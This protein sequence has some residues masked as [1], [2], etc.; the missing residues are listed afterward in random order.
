MKKALL[1]TFSLITILI[2]IL[3]FFSLYGR[4]L[5]QAEVCNALTLSMKQAMMQAQLEVGGPAS[6]D[7]WIQNF[8]QSLS[9]Q[10]QSKSELTIHIYQA[11]LEKGLL[12]AEAI[13]SFPNPIG[14][15]SSVTTGKQT[16]ILEEYYADE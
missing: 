9:T 14:T 6:T 11:D 8:A 1:S 16:I 10:I 12:C 5:R 4:L 15:S 13:L 2:F 7:E 3:I